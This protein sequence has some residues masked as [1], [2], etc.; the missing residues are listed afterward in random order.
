MEARAASLLDYTM[1]HYSTLLFLLSAGTKGSR[2]EIRH[3]IALP[4][5]GEDKGL[6][7]SS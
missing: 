7:Y 4:G 1:L 3:L 6:S 5:G 2:W